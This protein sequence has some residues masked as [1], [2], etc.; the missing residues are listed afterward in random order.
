M[1]NLSSFC[2]RSL[3]TN[4]NGTAIAN[5]APM[6]WAFIFMLFFCCSTIYAQ[7]VDSLNQK[8]TFV[9]NPKIASSLSAVL[10]GAGQVYNR[11][12]WKLIPIY[13]GL[14]AAG[15]FFNE[16]RKGYREYKDAY[17]ARYVDSTQVDPFPGQVLS[18]SYLNTEIEAHRKR[19][20]L[21]IIAMAGIYAI[22]I[23]EAAVDAHLSSFD[24]SEDLSLEIR[25]E[26]RRFRGQ[27]YAMASL[28]FKF[29]R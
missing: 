14:A 18:Q 26:L 29:R 16:Q 27:D 28:T 10:P 21:G 7:K 8:K 3:R 17:I 15:Y 5:F 22:Q 6:R 9:P 13:G 4:Q 24:V 19:L 11:S 12:Y 23:V 20:E 1:R 25:P 2:R